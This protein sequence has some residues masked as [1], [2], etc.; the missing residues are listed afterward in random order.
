M[1]LFQVAGLDGGPIDLPVPLHINLLPL[2]RMHRPGIERHTPGFWVQHETGNSAIGAGARFHR[3]FLFNGAPNDLGQ[4]QQLSYH[5]TVDD[6]EIFQMVPI[7]EVTW[8]AA[9]G[10]G[11]GNMSGI[12]CEMCINRDGDMNRA[13]QNAEALARE[14]CHRLGLTAEQVKRHWDF[15][16]GQSGCAEFCETP[17]ERRHHCP[18]MMLLDNYWPTFVANVAR[19]LPPP[20]QP[21]MFPQV[22]AFHV[23]ANAVA[24]ARSGPSRAYPIERNFPAGTEV[25]C[26]GFWPNGENVNG[27]SNWVRTIGPEHLAIHQT[28]VAEHI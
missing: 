12:S 23:P 3:D 19:P 5:F 15:N 4:E 6:H 1:P 9:D 18:E 10:G 7:D 2:S 13:R 27:E 24:T 28:G 16:F 14:I 21:T 22:R 11:P 25:Q 26:D 20:P 17:S 8:Q